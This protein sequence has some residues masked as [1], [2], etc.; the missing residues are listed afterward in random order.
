MSAESYI[1]VM[2]GG[3]S[4]LKFA[5]FDSSEKCVGRGIISEIG[6]KTKMSAKGE[7]FG[8]RVNDLPDVTTSCKTPGGAAGVLLGWLDTFLPP[9]ALLAVGHR[10][11]HGR[12]L[13]KHMIVRPHLMAYMKAL[14]PMAPLHQPFNVEIIEQ[15][16]KL[17]PK[18]TQVACFDTAFHTTIPPLHRRYAIPRVWHDKGVCRYGYHGL[19]YD[20]ISSRLK[21]IAPHAFAGKTVVCHLGNGSS[22]CAL[23]GGKS[24]DTSMGFTVLE[25][26]V[27]GT[28]PG[29]LD[30]GIMLYFMREAKMDEKAIERLL[31]HDCGLV[32]VS[33]IS[34]NMA[35]LLASHEPSAREAIDLFC[36]RVV[37]EVGGFISMLGG[38]DALVFT[39]GIG[40][41]ATPVR[42]QI[43]AALGWKGLVLDEAKNANGDGS[44]EV[45]ISTPQS[46][47]EIW[48]IPTNEELVIARHTREL[49]N[50]QH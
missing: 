43:V 21:E 45:K 35:D 30:A 37:R 41:H 8:D 31:Y 15:V 39:G 22:L 4:S 1:L 11:L 36:L 6:K 19:S 50:S 49:A 40:E 7:I 25:G 5:L 46:S 23:M 28:R 14:I 47:A 13:R 48:L 18:V 29:N 34:S 33:G 26:L 38:L 20:Y 32:G 9:N 27:M 12:D 3:S 16:A 44:A 24:F 17:Y 10:V 42:E 2:N